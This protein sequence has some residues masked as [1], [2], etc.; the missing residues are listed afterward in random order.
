MEGITKMG[1]GSTVNRLRALG[2]VVTAIALIAGAGCG[3]DDE[4]K[5]VGNIPKDRKA[6]IA[7]FPKD[8][9]PLLG[10]DVPTPV[11]SALLKV[12]RQGPGTLVLKDSGGELFQG[13]SEAFID[14]WKKVTGWD[15]KD[16]SPVAT[17]G[18]LR[19]QV[20]TGRPE[21]DMLEIGS[22]GEAKLMEDNNLLDP[23]DTKLM[24]P[25]FEQFPEEY[26]HTGKWIQYSF[27]G[28]VLVWDLREWPMSGKHPESAIKDL[29]NTRDFPGKR[30]L[31]NYPEFAGTLE[32]PLLASG[33]SPDDLYP[34]DVD[35]ALD[36]LETM[37]DDLVFWES[38][39]E[40]VQFIAN[41]NC[42][43]GVAWHGRPALRLKEN[44]DL[45]VGA[46]WKDALLI[47]AAYG[48]PKGAKNADAANSLLAFAFTPK[49]QCDYINALG[50]GIPMDESCID[51]FG[52]KWGVTEA[53]RALT[54]VHQDPNY[55]RKNIDQLI[56]KF[57]Q[58]LAE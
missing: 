13:E 41:G 52:K 24:Q 34:L 20:A 36:K 42:A 49:N 29:F 47:D 32:Y 25:L 17:P 21:W 10:D 55:Y 33:V 39:A 15:V 7:A 51:D 26:Q 50:Y 12:R 35:R 8:A 11:I 19:A 28:V 58:W 1:R 16:A 23:I 3:G 53:N 22:L 2:V 5:D 37:R 48:I 40:S 30:C 46:S 54:S 18:D 6:L 9:R 27:F 44:P 56:E 14:D 43:I 45:P 31:F 4:E 38:G 57:N